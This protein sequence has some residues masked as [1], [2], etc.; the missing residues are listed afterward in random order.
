M[1]K[2]VQS[3]TLLI[4]FGF[5]SGQGISKKLQD[6]VKTLE[7]DD[8]LKSGMLAFYVVDQKTGSVVLNENGTIGL[9]FASSQKVLTSV[10]ALELLG[11]TYRYQTTLAY[12]GEIQNG[13]LTGNIYVNG[14]GDP[15]T[16]SW[17]YDQTK[18]QAVLNKWIKAIKQAGIN[19]INGSIIINNNWGTYSVPG[20]WIW[21]DI[22]NY[23]GAGATGFNWRENQYDIK[24][25]SGNSVGDKVTIVATLPRLRDVNLISELTTGR[26][27]SGDN[28]YIYLAP[29]S[30]IG[31]IRGTIP[32][33]ENAFT[34]SGSFPDPAKQASNLFE[35]EFA[36]Q[37]IVI[38]PVSN[39]A[40]GLNTSGNHEL[41]THQSP[42]LDSI[43]YWFLR[44]SIN[45]YGEALAKTLGFEKK[46]EASTEAGV[47]IIKAF[48]K[49]R[50][51]EP[52]SINMKDGSG[53]SP[54]N[55]IT[56]EALAK[57]MRYAK[58]QPYFNSF[59]NALPEFNGMKMK[60]GTI[61]GVKSFTGYVGGYTFAIVVSN[62]NGSSS[63]MVRKMYKL[64]D[65]LK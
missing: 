27:G 47:N 18:E 57:V 5:A 12:N 30:S 17:R 45:L 32:P 34:I 48:W 59:Y 10:A 49:E 43:N 29:Y 36:K 54:Q 55:R 38:S 26:A 52:T 33:N 42:P 23:Y 14:S 37:G 64:L 6:A 4:V 11:T 50:G 9:P 2:L 65:L 61:G 46:K 20:G 31:Y 40:S 51:I 1:K 44:K 22:G 24:L 53:L 39:A 15:T 63:E 7:M 41:I 35:E 13:T 56:A 3:I 8:Q 16:G 28:A 21:D 25:K 58:S 62:F 60:S 19:R